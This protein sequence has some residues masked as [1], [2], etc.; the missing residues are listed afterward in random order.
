[1]NKTLSKAIL[2]FVVFTSCFSATFCQTSK[3]IYTCSPCNLACDSLTF[4][5]PGVCPHCR[6]N[7]IRT[8]VEKELPIS[9][10]LNSVRLDSFMNVLQKRGLAFGSLAI[11]MNGK[12]RYQRALGYSCLD[13]NNKVMSGINTRYRI[14]SVTKLFTAVMV[15]QLIEEGKI[16]LDDKLHRY[17]PTIPNAEKITIAHLLSHRS[18]LHDY[19]MGTNFQQ[20]MYK[21]KAH[22]D[23]L[24]IIEKGKADFEPGTKADYSN[25]NY[26]L[27]G[28]II[29]DVC[30]MPYQEALQRRIISRIGL[31]DTYYG[32]TINLSRNESASFKYSDSTWTKQLETDL[33]IHGGAGSIVSTPTSLVKFINE[34]FTHKLVSKSSLD[35]MKTLADGYGMGL[36]ANKYGSN[37][38]F[39]HNGRID[40][41]YTAVW[42]YPQYEMAIA[43][44]TNGINYPRRELMDNVLQICF[45]ETLTFPISTFTTSKPESLD[46]FQGIYSSEQ[47]PFKIT[48]KKEGRQ[49]LLGMKDAQIKLEQIGDD[50]F[51]NAANGYYFRF[52]AEPGTLEVM[53]TDYKY[54][55][56]KE[57]K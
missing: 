39:G 29:E 44:C 46:K 34:L 33:S 10:N 4:F 8:Q 16:R 32:G 13:S 24:N 9:Q 30:K 18:G 7:L 19:T 12:I 20:W 45:N 27:L 40:E 42:Y 31:K 23:L 25:T 53:E 48:C 55:F 49:L 56:K 6:M 35:Q 1:M 21:P 26:L 17:F 41:F 3:A 50:Y 15:F 28:Y 5:K 36:F 2:V 54:Y 57:K 52:N 47:L 38:S 43:Y 51:T 11:L 37:P 22:A 14:G